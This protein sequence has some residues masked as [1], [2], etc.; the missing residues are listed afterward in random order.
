MIVYVLFVATSFGSEIHEIF[1]SKNKARHKAIQIAEA[2][3][4]RQNKW[5]WSDSNMSPS[6]TYNQSNEE[7]LYSGVWVREMRVNTD[8]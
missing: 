3:I 7:Y 1:V 4:G 8:E 2:H 6:C 5:V